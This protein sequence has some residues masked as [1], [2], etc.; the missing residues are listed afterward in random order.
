MKTQYFAVLLAIALLSGCSN[1]RKPEKVDVRSN[2]SYQ[3][4]KKSWEDF[5]KQKDSLWTVFNEST[6][7]IEVEKVREM[8]YEMGSQADW[9]M[10]VGI[11]Y[12][13]HKARVENDFQQ[14][15]SAHPERESLFCEEKNKWENYHEAVL[16]VAELEDHGSSGSLYIT[17][18]LEQSL[19]LWLAS[20]YN[21]WLFE[22][23]K[24]FSFPE[25]TFTSR[26]IDDAY[27]A[28]IKHEDEGW[29]NI[30][31]DNE[32]DGKDEHH[33]A[34]EYEW[35][36]WNEWMSFRK[37]VSKS[38]P[39][40]LREIYDGCT[41][42][43]MRTK[44]LQLKNQNMGLGLT[45]NDVWCCLLPDSCTDKELLEYP[46]FNIAMGKYISDLNSGKNH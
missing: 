16:A 5:E 4:S 37:T 43:A 20:F 32:K 46:G 18:V 21:L 42:L 2:S 10:L 35:Q 13:K 33:K 22:Q 45:S 36:L 7:A 25:T 30:F 12:E 23:D 24:D 27:S 9:S 44:L 38:L 41:N 31:S 1:K 19:D 29:H 34:I 40:D 28:Y 15:V 8:L 26:M 14:F 17:G 6:D 39:K 3:T 11:D